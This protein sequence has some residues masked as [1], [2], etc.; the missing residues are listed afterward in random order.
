MPCCEK[1][2][3][4]VGRK[5][6]GWRRS[7]AAAA[8]LSKQSTANA[9]MITSPPRP[10]TGGYR[11]HQK[12][13]PLDWAPLG[14]AADLVSSS[15]TVRLAKAVTSIDFSLLARRG[16]CPPRHY[17]SGQQFAEVGCQEVCRGTSQSRSATSWSRQ[18][19]VCAPNCLTK[20]PSLPTTRP[21]TS[22]EPAGVASSAHKVHVIVR[23][24][25]LPPHPWLIMV[26]TEK[27]VE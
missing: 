16:P 3:R 13:R 14:G 1:L 20:T 21:Y 6:D 24:A 19:N 10:V 5:A 8:R 15:G 18:V 27:L 22:P 26:Q 12:I 23:C 25:R 9:A 11:Q 17:A 4:R 7:N 2:H